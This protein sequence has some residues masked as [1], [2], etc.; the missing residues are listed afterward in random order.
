MDIFPNRK[1]SEHTNTIA[2]NADTIPWYLLSAMVI[3]ISIGFLSGTPITVLSLFVLARH[4]PNDTISY[5]GMLWNTFFTQGYHQLPP[6]FSGKQKTIIPPD[7]QIEKRLTQRAVVVGAGELHR[8]VVVVVLRRR[9]CVDVGPGARGCRSIRVAVEVAVRWRVAVGAVSVVEGVLVRG[10]GDAV[11]SIR[12]IE[13]ET[14]GK[15]V[16]VVGAFVVVVVVV[17]IVMV[18]H[19]HGCVRLLVVRRHR[20]CCLVRVDVLAPAD[21]LVPGKTVGKSVISQRIYT[22]SCRRNP[23]EAIQR[24]EDVICELYMLH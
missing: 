21:V 19:L 18:I 6:R 13:L 14:W 15:G 20:E 23:S 16:G 3:I 4:C 8:P 7:R 10:R 12:S 5:F 1:L 24:L 11:R 9:G 17:V 22:D 2:I